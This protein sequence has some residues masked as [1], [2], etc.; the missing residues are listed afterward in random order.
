MSAKLFDGNL[1]SNTASSHGSATGHGAQQ[2]PP[3][4]LPLEQQTPSAPRPHLH[5]EN[6]SGQRGPITSVFALEDFAGD[7]KVSAVPIVEGRTKIIGP[8]IEQG[9]SWFCGKAEE[10][11][12]EVAVLETQLAELEQKSSRSPALLQMLGKYFKFGT[13]EK[14]NRVR[15]KLKLKREELR[16]FEA[17]YWTLGSTG[18]VLD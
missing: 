4:P 12:Q 1:S 14:L 18:S 17:Q 8:I 2:R 11:H 9:H 16:R 6:I 3:P 10:L 5:T 7:E 15:F 13:A